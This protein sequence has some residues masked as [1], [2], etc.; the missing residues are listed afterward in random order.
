MEKLVLNYPRGRM[1]LYVDKFFPCK[2][3]AARKIFPL[4]GKWATEEDFNDLWDYLT[5][6]YAEYGY[7]AEDFRL[8]AEEARLK[9]NDRM[10][11]YYNTR[12]KES[13]TLKK[14]TKRNIELLM[15]GRQI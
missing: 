7:E 2:L 15:G 4:I 8:C 3:N 5:D 10:F 13:E 14:R 12:A 6:R 9:E 1:E 11:C